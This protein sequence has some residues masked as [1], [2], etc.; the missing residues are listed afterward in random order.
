LERWYREKMA[1]KGTGHSVKSLKT[2]CA[3]AS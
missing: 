3:K 2:A 1:A